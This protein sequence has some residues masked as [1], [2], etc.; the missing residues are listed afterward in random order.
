MAARLP[1]HTIATIKALRAKGHSI[2]EVCAL[3]KVKG[4]GTVHRH[5]Q[6]IQLPFGPLKRGSKKKIAFNTCKALREQGYTYRG[7]AA[8]LGCAVSAVHR[9]LKTGKAAA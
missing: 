2:S 8:A 3:A 7:I 5:T 6:G 1:D 4:R 9:T